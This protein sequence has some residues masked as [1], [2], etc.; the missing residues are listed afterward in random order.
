MQKMVS[1]GNPRLN[2]R[3]GAEGMDEL[4]VEGGNNGMAYEGKG[5]LAGPRRNNNNNYGRL[6]TTSNN[7]STAY[8]VS[9]P[10]DSGSVSQ[11]GFQR[12]VSTQ[13]Q[14]MRSDFSRS[15]I[16]PRNNQNS[17]V[18][19]TEDWKS[20]LISGG[21][22]KM[23]L[24]PVPPPSTR[25]FDG[26]I[27]NDPAQD[28][29]VQSAVSGTGINRP[30]FQTKTITFDPNPSDSTPNALVLGSLGKYKSRT[31]IPLDDAAY[32]EGTRKVVQFMHNSWVDQTLCDVVIF[33]DGGDI[34][35][36][37]TVLGAY[38]PTLA[39]LFRQNPSGP[40]TLQHTAQINMSD[41][42]RETV[43]D[44]INFLYTT[45]I[46]LDCKTIGPVVSCAR[47]LDLTVVVQICEDYLVDTCDA[48]NI[49]LHY[50]VA[51]NN[52]LTEIR[53]RFQNI[54]AQG[55]NEIY[56]HKH[57]PFLPVD[58]LVAILTSAVLCSPELDIF[59]AIVKWTDFSR[60]ERLPYARQLLSY[61]R[62][63]LIE[64]EVL[65]TQVQVVD[66]I[67][68]SE[69]REQVLEAYK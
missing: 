11:S 45:D 41:Y 27:S 36:H 9:Q 47:Q 69:G 43:S 38:S 34:M 2:G 62:F 6:N 13:D 56:K 5:N 19:P 61:V 25:N 52:D 12:G 4:D 46:Q 51:A 44:V 37:Q 53:D 31:Q 16:I 20:N 39:S 26:R 65:A 18:S 30:P 64:P 40:G 59:Y 17:T 10:F 57:F 23:A 48:D 22:P 15:D 58:R 14:R 28:I 7:Q 49:I 33:T 55:F 63:Q 3:N 66:W 54:I 8:S 24:P 29:F 50:S 35:A 21:D 68:D 42:P 1:F 67:F 60:Q 32:N